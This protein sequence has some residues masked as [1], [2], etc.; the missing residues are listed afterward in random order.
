LIGADGTVLVK[1]LGPLSQ[2]IW[3]EKFMPH[4]VAQGAGQ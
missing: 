2:G 3:Q 4:L 1:H